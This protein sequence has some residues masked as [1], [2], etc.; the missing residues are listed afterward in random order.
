MDLRIST[1]YN[2]MGMVYTIT[3][4]KHSVILPERAVTEA[5]IQDLAEALETLKDV[6]DDNAVKTILDDWAIAAE[7]KAN[8]SLTS[9]KIKTVLDSIDASRSKVNAAI[10]NWANSITY[11]P[12]KDATV[13]CCDYATARPYYDPN[14]MPKIYYHQR[15]PSKQPADVI[16]D[17][18]DLLNS[19]KGLNIHDVNISKP[20]LSIA[21]R[22]RHVK[23]DGKWRITLSSNVTW[24]CLQ[25]HTRTL[26]VIV[27]HEIFDRLHVLE[28]DREAGLMAKLDTDTYIKLRIAFLINKALKHTSYSGDDIFKVIE[29]Y[30]W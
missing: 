22:I 2:P 8:G 25:G 5:G 27:T 24:P 26:K 19:N 29:V 9:G 20:Q 28:A 7:N 3:A 14:D 17:A 18:L 13:A 10:A 23:P 1:E 11:D 30:D 21:D 15:F 6:S 12:G 16:R 4:G